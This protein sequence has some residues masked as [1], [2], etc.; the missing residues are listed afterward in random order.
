MFATCVAVKYL[1]NVT[2]AGPML[3]NDCRGPI[4]LIS[5]TPTTTTT[6]LISVKKRA[7]HTCTVG[8]V[9]V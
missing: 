4:V 3:C 7:S 6:A 2:N 5:I 1:Y 8:I 9:F